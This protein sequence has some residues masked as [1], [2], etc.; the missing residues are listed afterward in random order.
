MRKTA[1][2][3]LL[4]MI[5]FTLF[6]SLLLQSVRFRLV[7]ETSRKREYTEEIIAGGDRE[8]LQTE[9]DTLY[10]Q[11]REVN[12]ESSLNE[13]MHSVGY[14]R[15]GEQVFIFPR[16]ISPDIPQY[17][18]PQEP[19]RIPWGYRVLMWIGSPLVSLLLSCGVS[20]GTGLAIYLVRRFRKLR[21]GTYRN[22]HIHTG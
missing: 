1:V 22:N 19:Q 9:V 20:A 8:L 10:R 14:S 18:E 5:I 15:K 4:L 17:R 3:P 13:I 11:S 16:D 12:S 6:L 2:Y 7:S 21:K